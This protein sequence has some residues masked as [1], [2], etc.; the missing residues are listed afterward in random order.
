MLV[1]A[2]L[3]MG[4]P[5]QYCISGRF[6]STGVGFILIWKDVESRQLLRLAMARMVEL[7]ALPLGLAGAAQLAMLPTPLT[8]S[9]IPALLFCQLYPAAAGLLLKAATVIIS[10]AHTD[11]LL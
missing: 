3:L 6:S 5:G 4:A 7:M 1:N 9:P 2:M 11:K 10:P 8:G